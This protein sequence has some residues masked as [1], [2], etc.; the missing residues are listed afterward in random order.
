MIETSINT[1]TPLISVVMPIK[2][3]ESHLQESIACIL[4]QTVKNIE[5]LIIA[6]DINDRVVEIINGFNDPRIRLI[7]NPK[8]SGIAAAL[9]QGFK[10]SRGHFIARMDSDDLCTSNRFKKQLDFMNAHPDVGICGTFQIIFGGYCDGFNRTAVTHD[11]IKVGLLFGPTMLHPTVFFRAE[12]IHKYK[13]YYDESAYMCEDYEIW[14][15][16]AKLTRLH[17]IP[18]NLNLYRWESKKKW[19][20]DIPSLIQSLN[21]IWERELKDLGMT[22]TKTDLEIHKQ[23][24]GRGQVEGY[25][26]LLKYHKH[27]KKIV[28]LNKKSRIYDSDLLDHKISIIWKDLVF[29]QVSNKPLGLVLKLLRI[30]LPQTVCQVLSRI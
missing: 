1:D 7:Q 23:I 25:R 10:E 21:S 18:E 30:I 9:N 15:R 2:N 8:R 5:F 26:V 28:K 11:E 27:L 13:L 16:A 17:T 3:E 22:P 19:E 24:T 4:N 12:I 14:A 6:D 20:L 29:R